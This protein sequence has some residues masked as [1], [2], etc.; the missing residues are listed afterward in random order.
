MAKHNIDKLKSKIFDLSKRKSSVL[1]SWIVKGVG[2]NNLTSAR[3]KYKRNVNRDKKA[4]VSASEL[5]ADPKLDE[6]FY[7]ALKSAKNSNALMSNI[8][9]LEKVYRKQT[10][11]VLDMA[12]LLFFLRDRKSKRSDKDSK[13]LKTLSLLW[14]HLFREITHS[15]QRG[16]FWSNTLFRVRPIQL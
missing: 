15:R 11:V 8:D 7:A 6:T 10:D 9:Q 4:S 12:K 1:A 2:E 13:A 5:F 14:A 16:P 3:E